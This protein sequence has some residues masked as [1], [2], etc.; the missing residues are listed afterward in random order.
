MHVPLCENRIKTQ[1]EILSEAK[2]D[3]LVK[4]HSERSEES[5]VIYEVSPNIILAIARPKWLYLYIIEH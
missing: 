5:H 4:C 3:M 2:N 1:E